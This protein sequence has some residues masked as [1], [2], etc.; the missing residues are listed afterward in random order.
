MKND[1]SRPRP[2]AARQNKE[3]HFA[4]F[5]LPSF[6][7]DCVQ[8]VAHTSPSIAV[9]V[10]YS[11]LAYYTP[12]GLRIVSA[13]T[14][15]CKGM[16]SLSTIHHHRR[17]SQFTH[18]SPYS[19]HTAQ[20]SMPTPVLSLRLTR[21]SSRATPTP[22]D[23]GGK[24]QARTSASGKATQS[25]DGPTPRSSAR[26]GKSPGYLQNYDTTGRPGARRLAF[27]LVG[28]GTT[29]YSLDIPSSASSSAGNRWAAL[30][31]AS[32]NR[33]AP[34]ASPSTSPGSAAG[35]M[36]TYETLLD[37][38]SMGARAAG[39]PRNGA[40]PILPPSPKLYQTNRPSKSHIAIR[41]A[42]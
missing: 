11:Y 34:G 1:V 4:C 18:H 20:E 14:K 40:S 23:G 3:A 25:A 37:N 42:E 28:G 22:D 32:P 21:M 41:I 26:K 16:P 8:L 29:V 24:A 30:R 38:P 17:R 27:P 39:Q 33:H 2:I 12:C 35:T 19:T 7:F 15:L 13:P 6:S 5:L 36:V 9:D 31:R 10:L